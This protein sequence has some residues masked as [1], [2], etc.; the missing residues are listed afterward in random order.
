[1]TTDLRFAT[2]TLP[3]PVTIATFETAI[4]R[5]SKSD[6]CSAFCDKDPPILV[7]VDTIE[8]RRPS[9]SPKVTTDLRFDDQDLPDPCDSCQKTTV[10][11][12]FAAIFECQEFVTLSNVRERLQTLA[13][14]SQALADTNARL[15]VTSWTPRP[16]LK[17]GAASQEC[18]QSQGSGRSWSRNA[19]LSLLLNSRL[20]AASQSVNP[21]AKRRTVVT[22]GLASGE[23]REEWLEEGGERREDR[24]EEKREERGDKREERTEERKERR[25]RKERGKDRG[26]R[27]EERGGKREGR[28][29]NGERYYW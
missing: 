1:M 12:E 20:V 21:A 6:D 16:N 27:G 8:T 7:I 2:K 10:L 9:A 11:C 22:F 24:G 13:G 17:T 26:E 3:I 28:E 19:E 23:E 5:E 15:L 29:E 4:K 18:Q 14:A 25:G